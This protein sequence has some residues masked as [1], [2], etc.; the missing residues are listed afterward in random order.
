M[1]YSLEQL[2]FL[3]QQV[4][5]RSMEVPERKLVDILEDVNVSLMDMFYVE[6]GFE[7]L[8]RLLSPSASVEFQLWTMAL[9]DEG[10]LVQGEDL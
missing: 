6:D 7:R 2:E 10:Y 3:L 8:K 5:L 4:I 9:L 1:N